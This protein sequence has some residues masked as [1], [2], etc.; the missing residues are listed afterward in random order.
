[1]HKAISIVSRILVCTMVTRSEDKMVHILSLLKEIPKYK[2]EKPDEEADTKDIPE[3]ETEEPADQ[4]HA[5]L[6]ILTPNQMLCRL[7]II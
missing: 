7:A 4:K 5:G 1:M 3:L 6:K 2:N